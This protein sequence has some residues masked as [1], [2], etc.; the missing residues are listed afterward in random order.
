MELMLLINSRRPVNTIALVTK[1]AT[2]APVPNIG[3]FSTNK[4]PSCR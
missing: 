4:K 3:L 2:V 1:T